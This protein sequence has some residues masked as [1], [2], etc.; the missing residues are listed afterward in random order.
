MEN[1]IYIGLDVDDQSFHG[2][3][4]C[5][6]TGETLDF[7]CH[8]TVKSLAKQLGKIQNLFPDYL[9]HI[10]Y[11]ATYLSFSL[12]RQISDLGYHCDVI[13]VSSIPRIYGNQVKTDRIDVAKLT[14]FYAAGLLTA[15]DIPEVEREQDQ[16][17]MRSRQYMLEQLT[18]VR[19]HIQSLLRRN[20]LHFK[21]ETKFLSHWTS[22]HMSWLEK[23]IEEAQGSF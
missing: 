18:Q 15:I 11:E 17:L 2:N 22:H 12:Q 16:D 5:K 19:T 4:V 6:E 23:K 13:A 9:L 10:C 14:G 1:I 8:P 21:N 3:W 7:Q 20:N